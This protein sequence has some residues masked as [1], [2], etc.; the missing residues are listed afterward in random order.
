MH[1]YPGPARCNKPYSK[2][3]Q[4]SGQ[5]INQHRSKIKSVIRV[6]L[7]IPLAS[8]RIPLAEALICVMNILHFRFVTQYWYNIA[9]TL[10]Y[11]EKYLEESLHPK[12]AV[13]RSHTSKSTIMV[14]EPVNQHLS[15]DKQQEQDSNPAWNNH[16]VAATCH[17][18][19]DDETWTQSEITQ[20]LVEQ[21]EFSCVKMHLLNHFFDHIHQLHNLLNASSTLPDT[22]MMNPK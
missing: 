21:S 13:C 7:V 18:I 6:T 5:E 19:K 8:E 9:A 11:M 14:S 16:S 4:S 12:D 1:P 20:H 17:H 2:A 15:L 22:A 10:E 3:T